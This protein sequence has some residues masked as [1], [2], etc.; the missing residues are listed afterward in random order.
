MKFRIPASVQPMCLCLLFLGSAV[1]MAQELFP[2]PAELQPDIDFWVKVYTEI[3]TS[4][5]FIHDADNV[6]VIYES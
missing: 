5:G 2:R 3:D 1:S 6:S 4:S